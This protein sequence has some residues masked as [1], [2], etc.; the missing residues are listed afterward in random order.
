MNFLIL[1]KVLNKQEIN[2]LYHDFLDK[3]ILLNGRYVERK[4][5]FSFI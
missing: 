4:Q 1:L 2:I 3:K 5:L